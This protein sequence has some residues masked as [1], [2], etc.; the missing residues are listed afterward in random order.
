MLNLKSDIV[1]KV[2]GYYFL[3]PDARHYVRELA[4]MLKVDPGNLSKK[5]SELKREGLFLME[6]EG[7]NRYFILNKNFSLLSEYKSIYET[8]FGVAEY[9]TT[10]LREIVGLKEAYIFGSY[11]KG[12]FEAGSDIDLLVIG[13]HDHSQISRRVSVLEKRWHREINIVDFSPEE[14]KKKMRNKDSFL[15]NIFSGQTIRVI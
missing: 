13:N 6:S 1:I 14:F 9:L 11:V 12:N 2:L 7:K 3:N 10:S 15:E 4:G 5:M 8:K